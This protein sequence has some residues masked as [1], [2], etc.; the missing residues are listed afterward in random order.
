M[1]LLFSFSFPCSLI[2]V[3]VFCMIRDNILLYIC[4]LNIGLF[5]H[6]CFVMYLSSYLIMCLEELKV[7]LIL[8]P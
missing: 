8:Q 1:I 6:V 4:F 5:L 7:C 2:R 3:I